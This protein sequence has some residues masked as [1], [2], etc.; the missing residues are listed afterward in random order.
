MLS[1]LDGRRSATADRLRLLRVGMM[2]V[3]MVEVS[4][5]MVVMMVEVSMKMVVFI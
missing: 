1:S 3:K 5:R 4:I 2:V